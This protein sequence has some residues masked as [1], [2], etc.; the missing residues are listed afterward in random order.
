L[1]KYEE[2]V[3]KPEKIVR[4][5]CGFIGETYEASMLNFYAKKP[6]SL[7]LKKGG[8]L[9][10]EIDSDSIGNYKNLATGEIKEIEAEC[11]HGMQLMEYPFTVSR[12]EPVGELVIQPPAKTNIVRFI[13]D[14]LLYYNW[15]LTRWKFGWMRW[16]I[17]LKVRGR[18]YLTLAPLRKKG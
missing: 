9:L 13:I 11:A 6:E 10:E 8:K 7:L 17:Q 2:L 12:S 4:E 15:N 1:V 18:Y 3:K 14:R 5:M 16:R